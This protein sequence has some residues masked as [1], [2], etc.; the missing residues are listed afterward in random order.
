MSDLKKLIILGSGPAGYSAGI[1]AARAGLNPI[2]VTGLEVGGQ[3]TT[4]TDVE[5]WPGDH[6]DLQ[7]PDLMMRMKDHAEKFNVEIINDHIEEVDLS[8]KPI[9]LK[10]NNEYFAES[11]II[12]TG[13]S[14]QYLGLESEQKFL[15]KGVSACATCDGFF[16]KEKEVAVIG[17]GNTAAEE[18]LYLSNIC[19]KVHLIHRRDSLRA[20]KFYKIESFQKQMKVKLS[21]IG[22]AN[23]KKLL[24][25]S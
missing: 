25:T 8:E 1:Y 23:S 13:A 11:L 2:L 15:G 17:G 10:G 12:A 20:E 24:E 22:I 21:S 16:Y 19:S 7:G 4:T 3:L 5:N 9:K 6:D 18:A 14:A